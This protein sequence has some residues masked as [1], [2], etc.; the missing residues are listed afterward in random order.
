[1][2]Q[3]SLDEPRASEKALG[4]LYPVLKNAKGEVIDGFHKIRVTN[5]VLQS[6]CKNSG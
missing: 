6:T 2:G 4:Q 3:H 5:P 1:M